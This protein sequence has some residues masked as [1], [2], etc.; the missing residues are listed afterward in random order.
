MR[1]N[2][3]MPTESKLCSVTYVKKLGRKTLKVLKIVK[4][5]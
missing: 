2:I 3:T 1:Q 4:K 5:E